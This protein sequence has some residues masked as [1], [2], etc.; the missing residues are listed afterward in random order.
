MIDVIFTILP[1]RVFSLVMAH[2]RCRCIILVDGFKLT[3]DLLHFEWRKGSLLGSCHLHTMRIDDARL[4][5]QVESV[6]LLGNY[7]CLLDFILEFFLVVGCCE[8]GVRILYET[9]C[10]TVSTSDLIA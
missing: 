1:I 9:I 2:L 10:A 5:L 7:L 4:F 3:C 6:M 8:F